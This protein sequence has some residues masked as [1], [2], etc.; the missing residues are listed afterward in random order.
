MKN[1]VGYQQ[2]VSVLYQIAQNQREA[3]EYLGDLFID[4][5]TRIY[6]ISQARQLDEL[7]SK[8]EQEIAAIHC[9]ESALSV[10]CSKETLIN[11]LATFGGGLLGSF[12]FKNPEIFTRSKQIAVDRFKR[13]ETFG[14]VIVAIGKG[15][16]PDDVH[17]VPLSE[18]ARNE[19]TTENA[20]K[21]M[22][23]SKG[24]FTMVE[25]HFYAHVDKLKDQVLKGDV[26]LPVAF[27]PRIKKTWKQA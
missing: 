27:F 25:S 22:L 16:I 18:Q 3:L 12:F 5:S 19:K 15:G 2:L 9:Q 7:R 1:S 20:V 11:G 24:Y 14:T 26:A 13:K 8:I 4:E 10:A 6:R 23:E 17:V 21:T